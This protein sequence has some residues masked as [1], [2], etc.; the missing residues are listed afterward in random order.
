M[1]TRRGAKRE[2]Y[3]WMKAGEGKKTAEGDKSCRGIAVS[4]FMACI[5][6]TVH[7]RGGGLEIGTMQH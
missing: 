7:F 3:Q 2:E 4:W 1:R 6:F 5:V